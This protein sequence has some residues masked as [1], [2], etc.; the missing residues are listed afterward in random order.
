MINGFSSFLKTFY[1]FYNIIFPLSQ[2]LAK[3]DFIMGIQFNNLMDKQN[4]EN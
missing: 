2:Y 1:I 3:W 4:L